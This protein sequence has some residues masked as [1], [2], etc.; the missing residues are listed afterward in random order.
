MTDYN[1][2]L[3]LPQTP[4]T[5]EISSKIVSEK[6]KKRL[7]LLKRIEQQRAYTYRNWLKKHSEA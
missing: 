2:K 4:L 5:P 7:A 1:L 3:P 6:R